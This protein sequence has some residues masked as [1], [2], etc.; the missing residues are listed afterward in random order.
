MVMTTKILPT[1]PIRTPHTTV[2][3]LQKATFPIEATHFL[4]GKWEELRTLRKH[5]NMALFFLT[6]QCLG[7][8]YKNEVQSPFHSSSTS[9]TTEV[10]SI[11]YYII[12]LIIN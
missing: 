12:A 11:Q 9:I 4:R 10:F 3:L 8:D 7:M 2:Q 6:F 1:C 5:N